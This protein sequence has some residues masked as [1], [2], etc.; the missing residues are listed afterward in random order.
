MEFYDLNLFMRNLIS[1]FDFFFYDL[2]KWLSRIFPS[3]IK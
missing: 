2:V 3:L 1:S